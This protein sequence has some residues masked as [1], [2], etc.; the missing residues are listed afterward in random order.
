MIVICKKPTK[1]LVKDLRYEVTG[2]YNSGRNQR[3]MEGKVEIKDLGRFVVTN[4]TDINGNP[5]PKVDIIPER[6]NFVRLEFDSIKKGDILVCISDSY[7]TLVKNGMYKIEK[8]E[9]SST[10]RSYGSNSYVHREQ[11]IKFEGIARKIKFSSWR[12]RALTAQEVREISLG[13][14]LEGKEP[15]VIKTS[16]IR[17]IDLVPNKTL[18]LM[19]NLSLSIIDEN[20]HHLSILEWTCQKT[21]TKLGLDKNDYDDL[22]KMSLEDI[23]KKIETI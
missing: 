19:R 21:G 13:S 4:F 14:L 6:R 15:E 20:R 3:W 11:S 16:K 17:K 2:L 9:S 1:K 22:L 18:E 12:F 5:L 8:L 10:T 23:L 7:K